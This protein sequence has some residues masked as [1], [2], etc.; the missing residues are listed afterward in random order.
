MP[1]RDEGGSDGILE[2]FGIPSPP[3]PPPTAQ[4]T[5]TNAPIVSSTPGPGAVLQLDT[6]GHISTAVIPRF[7]R[8]ST[9]VVWPG[10]ASLS[11]GTV[12]TH[13]LPTT[14]TSVVAIMGALVGGVSVVCAIQVVTL[15]A[16]TFTV[17]A[18]TIDASTPVAASSVAVY[19]LALT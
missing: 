18:Q 5:L 13:G 8:G 15:T 9:T 1:L 6:T 7:G 14:P 3:P 4:P 16:T 17:F 2:I 19:W 12:V 10:G 11:N